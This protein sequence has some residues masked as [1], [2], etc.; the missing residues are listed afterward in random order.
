MKVLKELKVIE[1][2]WNRYCPSFYNWHEL[3][4][5]KLTFYWNPVF[6][7]SWCCEIVPISKNAFRQKGKLIYLTKTI[8]GL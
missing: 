5:L 1:T 3:P 4:Y 8:M 6:Q 7:I 2:Y